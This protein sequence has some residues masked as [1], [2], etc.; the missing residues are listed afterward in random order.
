MYANAFVLDF[1]AIQSPI[2]WEAGPNKVR[3]EF[4]TTYYIIVAV[5]TVIPFHIDIV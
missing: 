5:A 4:C 3:F 1:R 2:E